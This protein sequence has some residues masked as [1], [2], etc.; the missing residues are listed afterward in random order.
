MDKSD[1]H[2]LLLDA[3]KVF[4]RIRYR[5]LF[6]KLLNVILLLLFS[7]WYYISTQNNLRIIYCISNYQV[8]SNKK[9]D[10]LIIIIIIIFI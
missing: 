5:L 10:I 4:D 2:D 3:S 8:I 7:V 9:V 1:V 6:S